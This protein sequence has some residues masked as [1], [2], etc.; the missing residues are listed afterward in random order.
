MKDKEPNMK[1]TFSVR[2]DLTVG[3]FLC[4]NVKT[5]IMKGAIYD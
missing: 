3:L 1:Q 4:Y 2:E 5:N